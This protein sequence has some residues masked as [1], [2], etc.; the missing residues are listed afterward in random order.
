[1]KCW[2]TACAAEKKQFK[3]ISM[4][5]GHNPQLLDFLFDPNYPKLRKSPDSLLQ[6]ARGLCSGDYLL[7][8][9]GLEIWCGDGYLHVS[10]LFDAEPAIFAMILAALASL[11]PKPC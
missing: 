5:L 7:V 3:A 11:A 6:D 9:L 1:M 2:E 8:K 10:E 4:C